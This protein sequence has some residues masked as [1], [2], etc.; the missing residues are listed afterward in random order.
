MSGL[1]DDF[2]E[3][4]E[5]IL[6]AFIAGQEISPFSETLVG[7]AVDPVPGVRSG[8]P[9]GGIPSQFG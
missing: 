1:G 9:D 4:V 7:A 2:V 3:D 6:L 8:A 5:S